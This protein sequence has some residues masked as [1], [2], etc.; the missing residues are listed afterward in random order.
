M[1][2]MNNLFDRADKRVKFHQDIRQQLQIKRVLNPFTQTLIDEPL[3]HRLGI[4]F[5]GYYRNR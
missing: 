3:A 4:L 1:N 5:N 2:D